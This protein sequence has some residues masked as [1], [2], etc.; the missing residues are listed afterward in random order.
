MPQETKF[1]TMLWDSP[2]AEQELN[3]TAKVRYEHFS[4]VLGTVLCTKVCA[5]VCDTSYYEVSLVPNT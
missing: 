1:P 5:K 2:E 4:K 3:G